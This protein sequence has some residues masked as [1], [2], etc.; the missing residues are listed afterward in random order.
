MFGALLILSPTMI[1]DNIGVAE[2]GKVVTEGG[3][4]RAQFNAQRG[5]MFLALVKREDYL[6]A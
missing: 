1:Y 2:Q 6:E 4:T 3:L 5:D